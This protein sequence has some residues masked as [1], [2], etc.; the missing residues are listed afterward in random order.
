MGP[1]VHR[2]EIRRRQNLPLRVEEFGPRRCLEPVWRGL[3][4]V[5]AE[6]VGDRPSRTS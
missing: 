2:E 5:F 3:E 1:D 6:D 4:A